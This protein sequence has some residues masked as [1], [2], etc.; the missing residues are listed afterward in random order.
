MTMRIVLP[1]ICVLSESFASVTNEE[2]SESLMAMLTT[3]LW[4]QTGT[5]LGVGVY[6]GIKVGSTDGMSG[7]VGA[8][9]GV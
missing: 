1:E 6:V 5:A 8:C 7:T 2:S 3:L 4:V 9:D